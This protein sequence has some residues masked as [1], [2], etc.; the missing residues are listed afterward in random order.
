VP[1]YPVLAQLWWENIA[2]AATGELS[3][4]EAMDNLATAQ[5]E[6]L[7]RL[8]RAG[9]G[10]ECGPQLNEERPAEEWFAEPGAPVPKLD[11]ERGEP[12]T[13]SYDELIAEWEASS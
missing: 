4:Q 12:A 13:V 9:A 6:V 8:E 7:G 1:D 10:G 2:P 5:D 3:A 11:D